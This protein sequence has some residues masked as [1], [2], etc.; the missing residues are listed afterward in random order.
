MA[1]K[2]K[3]KTK[4]SSSKK[5][6]NNLSLYIFSVILFTVFTLAIYSAVVKQKKSDLTF[7]TIKKKEKPVFVKQYSDEHITENAKFS[8]PKYSNLSFG[9]RTSLLGNVISSITKNPV[10]KQTQSLESG[11]W[12]WTPILQITPSYTEKIIEDCKKNGIRN[13]YLSIDSYLDIYVMPEGEEKNSQKNKFDS[14]V[15]NF[16][17]KANENGITVDAEAGWRNWAE[18]ANS[19]KAFATLNYAIEYNK[20]Q[21]YK[22]RGFQYDIEP[23]LLDYYNEDAKG[24]LNNFINLVDESVARL[25]ES[26]LTLSVV[27]PEFYDGSYESTPKIFYAGENLYPIEQLL[28]V[29][30]KRDD[31]SIII[32]AYRNF[33]QGPNGSIEISKDEIEFADKY[34]TK[35]ITAVETGDT[36]PAYITFYNL[37]KSYYK[38]QLSEL[39]KAFSKNKSFGGTATHYINTLAELQ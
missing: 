14:V 28:R 21:K 7:D 36:L 24:V 13:L 3:L 23:Y 25:D 30:D 22:F 27:I 10:I 9:N 4:R 1:N 8:N 6:R 37:R 26:D 11:S 39:T 38:T 31:S 17:K 2:E 15:S 18:L 32:M 29:L 5:K 34:N 33:S 16:I 12:L 20:N 19:Y 35:I